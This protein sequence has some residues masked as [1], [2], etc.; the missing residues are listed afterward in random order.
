MEKAKREL[1][2]LKA[3]FASA[4]T[5]ELSWEAKKLLQLYAQ[6]LTDWQH[7]PKTWITNYHQALQVFGPE[8]S[9]PKGPSS[10]TV[11]W[12][13]FMISF[14]EARTAKRLRTANLSFGCWPAR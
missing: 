2:K 12:L 6:G 4:K 9:N 13:L 14:R 8:F 10:R 1:S 5:P 3:Q 7:P 11:Y